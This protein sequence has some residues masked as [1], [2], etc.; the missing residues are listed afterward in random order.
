M[1]YYNTLGVPASATAAEI[2]KAYKSLAM[3]H[4]PDKGGDESTFQKINEAYGIL[5]DPDQRRRHDAG[6]GPA[7]MFNSPFSNTESAFNDLFN[8]SRARA[9][10]SCWIE[11]EDLVDGE[12]KILQLQTRAGVSNIE[13]SIPPGIDDGDTVSYPG[14]APDGSDVIISFRIR[15]HRTFV[16]N[17][18]N[19]V[20]PLQVSVWDLILGTTATI[21]NLKGTEIKIT[22][23]PSTQPG[24]YLRIKGHGLLNR[25]SGTKGDILCHINTH[26]PSNLSDD[27]I[28]EIKK[29][30]E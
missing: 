12:V 16:R 24:T 9:R 14:L 26:I 17:G 6:P 30:N 5:R 23:P 11:L 10:L 2:K 3:K 29:H 1:D 7:G 21:T 15:Q 18:I 25:Q 13:I 8:R 28:N 27:L 22:V 19:L 4:H 20:A